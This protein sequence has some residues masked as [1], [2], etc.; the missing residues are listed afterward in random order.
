M[1]QTHS[2]TRSCAGQYTCQLTDLAVTGRLANAL[3]VLAEEGD[4]IALAGP[5]GSGKTT[6]ARYFISAAGYREDVPSPTFNLLQV[7][8]GERLSVW[9]F[10]LY[11]LKRPDEVFELG[12][13]QAF[14]EGVTLI[15]WPE[16]MGE[17]LP[18]DV[19]TLDFKPG[20]SDLERQVGI[21]APAH[22]QARLGGCDLPVIRER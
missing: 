19:L 1:P 10:D 9:H 7:Y 12:L 5:I 22:W 18:P 2:S 21:N 20:Q 6:F 15:E 4:V 16:R 17:L 8:E 13:E 11:R 14:D 3:A